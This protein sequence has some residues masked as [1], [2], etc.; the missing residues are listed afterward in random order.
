MSGRRALLSEF[1][2]FG[3]VGAVG[4]V[5]DLSV[6]ALLVDGLGVWFGWAR[7]AGFIVAV[8]ANFFNNDRFT[9]TG[10]RE[11]STVVRWARFVAT[12]SMGMAVNY[13]VS[14]ALFLHVPLFS[15]LYPLAAACGTLA[16]M[17]I[18]FAGARLYA[19]RVGT[20]GGQRDGLDG[21]GPDQVGRSAADPD[22]RR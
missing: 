10:P 5:I 12:S 8:T 16:G 17:G 2:R 7:L 13:A 15:Q 3:L 19:F 21:G 14:M 11:A 4:T 18:N 1:L 22:S 9:F 6:I 20:G